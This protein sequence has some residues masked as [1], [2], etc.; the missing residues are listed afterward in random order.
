MGGRYPT[1]T[2]DNKAQ[3]I[4]SQAG[5]FDDVAVWNIALSASDIQALNGKNTFS[6]P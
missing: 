4:V 3:S 1:N 6:S 5:F 2:I